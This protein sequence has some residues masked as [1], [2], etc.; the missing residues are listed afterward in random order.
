MENFKSSE[1]YHKYLMQIDYANISVYSVWGANEFEEDCFL[2]EGNKIIA[3][4]NLE[5]FKSKILMYDHCFFDKSRFA[6]WLGS[7]KFYKPY[8]K[9]DYNLLNNFDDIFANDKEYLRNLLTNIGLMEDFALQINNLE[10]LKILK[11]KRVLTLKEYLYNMSIWRLDVAEFSKLEANDIQKI[12]L[13]LKK[14]YHLF[15][16]N[17]NIVY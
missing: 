2:I 7:E 3:F 17:I 4:K 8:T 10:M 12:K 13:Q 11:S 5:N 6:N 1:K 9:C 16:C 14:L 15:I